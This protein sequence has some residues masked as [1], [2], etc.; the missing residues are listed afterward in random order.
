MAEKA[1]RDGHRI[2]T[3]RAPAGPG[4]PFERL[5]DYA[6]KRSA[7]AVPKRGSWHDS[8]RGSWHDSANRKAAAE[9]LKSFIVTSASTS[10]KHI[11][12]SDLP[13]PV[14]HYTA[15]TSG[16]VPFNVVD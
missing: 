14:L 1:Y 8:K 5:L 7:R 12:I 9:E 3:V 16:D 4:D 10:A 6:Q 11:K 15:S 13:I 2:D